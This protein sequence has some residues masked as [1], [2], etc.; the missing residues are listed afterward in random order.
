[1]WLFQNEQRGIE[2][3]DVQI[4]QQ[5]SEDFVFREQAGQQHK[6]AMS[7]AAVE[8]T[9]QLVF[10]ELR[11]MAVGAPLVLRDDPG[12]LFLA[13]VAGKQALRQVLIRCN[14]HPLIESLL[15]RLKQL[16]YALVL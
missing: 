8:E 13:C 10:A 11:A 4:V 1:M 5:A 14:L 15:M 12:L 9:A 3:N 2:V 6:L 7:S 16:L